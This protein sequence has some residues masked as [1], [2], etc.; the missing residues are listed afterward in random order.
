M[1]P[2]NSELFYIAHK[3]L[4]IKAIEELFYEEVLAPTLD[5]EYFVLDLRDD[6]KYTFQA[7]YGAWSNIQIN[8]NSLKK[9]FLEE[10]V[11]EFTLS[12][13]FK[14]I[15]YACRLSDDTLAKFLEEGNQTIFS[16]IKVLENLNNLNMKELINLN[17][18]EIDS[19]LPGHPKLIMNK[20]RIGWS[21]VDI[22]KYSPEFNNQFQ[23]RWIAVNNSCLETGVDKNLDLNSLAL[24]SISGD[25]LSNINLEEYTVFPVHPWQ[26]DQYLKIQFLELLANKKII[27]LGIVGEFFKPQVSLRTLSQINKNLS[28][29]IKQSL[30]ILNT[31][32]VRGI[33]SKYIKTGHLISNS[34]DSIIAD[35]P[36]LSGRVIVLKELGAL[37]V[38]HD[39]FDNIKDCSYRYKEFLGVV[40]REN[41]ESKLKVNE[42]A[43]PT[44]ALFCSNDSSSFIE[45]LIHSSELSAKEWISKYFETVVTPLYHLQLKHGFG[46]VSHGQ[47]IILILENHIPSKL[48]IKDFHG[49][50][51]ISK[52][53]PYIE[54]ELAKYLDHLPPEYLIHDLITGHFITVLRYISRILKEKQ[55]MDED[56]FYQILGKTIKTY[57]SSADFIINKNISLL[58]PSFEKILVNK[59]RFIEGYNETNTR[60]KPQLGTEIV[61]P[62]V[63][64]LEI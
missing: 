43:I 50:L 16:E 30:S 61:N 59:V 60:L 33:P 4:I 64:K 40:W 18:L 63:K 21:E 27:D 31:S 36:K 28:F 35:D 53:S 6:V 37:R 11:I 7:K 56:L 48:M 12:D 8:A 10:E 38:K 3:N 14:E 22:K 15:Q 51:R 62:L 42:Q 52:N 9:F 13:F 5:G 19:L 26:W 24:D 25:L 32:C 34:I 20:G 23:L 17:Y 57:E 46:L 29:D 55:L 44:A 47:N 45:E 39:Y 58:R 2:F 41:V 49:D 1:I 54:T